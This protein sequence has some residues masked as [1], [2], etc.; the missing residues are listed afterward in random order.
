MYLKLL[1]QLKLVLVEHS[2]AWYSESL[3]CDT[4]YSHT[5]GKTRVFFRI[6]STSL[7]HRWM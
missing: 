4:I 1:I 7:K 5:K 6:Y 2:W 3:G